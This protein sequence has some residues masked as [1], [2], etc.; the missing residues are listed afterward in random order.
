MTM[1]LRIPNTAFYLALLVL[2]LV[3]GLVAPVVA[4]ARPMKAGFLLNADFAAYVLIAFTFMLKGL[5]LRRSFVAVPLTKDLILKA[6]G[7]YLYLSLFLMSSLLCRRLKLAML[8]DQYYWL[9]YAAIVPLT[10]SLLLILKGRNSGLASVVSYPVYLGL[11]MSMAFFPLVQMCW[12]PLLALPGVL[13]VMA[14]RIDNAERN[15]LERAFELEAPAA[16]G[17]LIELV[18][19]DREKLAPLEVIEPRFKI[20]PFLY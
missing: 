19:D 12:F 17:T 9:S 15:S 6:L 8:P 2:L 4:I 14:W 7:L 1:M 18:E 10:F 5:A 11:L 13:I 3:V 20:I 16:D